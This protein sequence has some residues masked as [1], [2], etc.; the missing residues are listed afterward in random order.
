MKGVKRSYPSLLETGDFVTIVADNHVFVGLDLANGREEVPL[1]DLTQSEFNY[2][3][4]EDEGIS[5]LSAISQLPAFRSRSTGSGA[6]T[7]F[8]GR[9]YHW[10]N[11]VVRKSIAQEH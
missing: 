6:M 5:N 4:M 3:L 10:D 7:S 11:G 1:H 2:L 9:K 8:R